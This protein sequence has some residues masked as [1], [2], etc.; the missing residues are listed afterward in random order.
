MRRVALHVALVLGVTVL[1]ASLA[2][3]SAAVASWGETTLRL[4]TVAFDSMAR[5][6]YSTVDSG[7][8]PMDMHRLVQLVPDMRV[9]AVV[10]QGYGVKGG[11][12]LE[13]LEITLFRRSPDSLGVTV[14]TRRPLLTVIDSALAPFRDG[15]RTSPAGS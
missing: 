11:R 7:L 14:R 2:A 12:A 15:R 3:Q 8:S 5:A 9:G 13:Y 6:L 4:P 10:H 1:P